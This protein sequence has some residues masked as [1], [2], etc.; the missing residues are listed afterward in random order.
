MIQE[1]T[2]LPLVLLL[3]LLQLVPLLQELILLQG[4]IPL[5]AVSPIVLLELEELTLIF[6]PPGQ[7]CL[8]PPSLLLNLLLNFQILIEAF[9]LKLFP[10]LSFLFPS[11]WASSFALTFFYLGRK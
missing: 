7:S 10:R 2:P 1:G 3:L 8:L 11:S 4:V 6:H 9:R 5:L